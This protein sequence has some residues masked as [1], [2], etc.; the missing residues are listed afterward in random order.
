MSIQ[1]SEIKLYRSANVS[2][3]AS[4]GGI[5]SS[6]EVVAG[7][8]ANLFPNASLADRQAGVTR[9]RKMFY[10]V[11]SAENLALIAP[12]LWMDSNTPGDDRIV[13]FPGTQRDAQSAIPGSPTFYGMGVTTAGVLAGGTSL[14]VQ[15]EDGTVSIFRNAGLVRI[16]D[17]A[18]PFSSGNEHWSLIS[19]T[20]TV[21]GN[22]VT[23]SLATPVPVGFLSGSKVSSVYAPASVS[24]S[25]DTVVLTAAGGSLTNQAANMIPNSIGGIEQNWTLTFTSATAFNIA[26]D[27]V[28]AVGSGNTS[29]G[30]AP[31]NPAFNKP[32]FTLNAALFGGSYV[33]GNMLTFSTHPAAVPLWVRQVV[34]DGAVAMSNN[35][36][37]IY[38]DGETS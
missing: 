2:D 31:N 8:P 28:G 38:I 16:S 4:N 18:D 25:I 15:V 14:S 7:A 33:A 26:G 17:R 23:F 27:T 19:G 22:V 3:L 29:S 6:V 20:P 37:S 12:R 1:A 11:G 5:M 35:T 21:V 30:A 24:P 36:F 34:P 13:F 10:K 32:Y 9:Y